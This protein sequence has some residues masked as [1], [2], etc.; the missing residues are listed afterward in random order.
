MGDFSSTVH[1]APDPKRSPLSEDRMYRLQM[2]DMSMCNVRTSMVESMLKFCPYLRKISLENIP[3][4]EQLL[5]NLGFT[6]PY[7]D[8]V[9]LAMCQG[10][11][12]KG[13]K[14][15]IENCSSLSH[16]NI[17][18]TCMSRHDVQSVIHSLPE[19]LLSLDISGNRE[20]ITDD[21]IKILCD[22]SPHLR[23]LELSDSTEITNASV[24]TIG[25]NLRSL[26]RISL[27]RCYSITPHALVNLTR[28]RSLTTINVFGMMRD[29]SLT[30]LETYLKRYKVNREPF[31]TVARPTPTN[32]KVVKM[33]NVVARSGPVV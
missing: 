18:W 5:I 22:Q 32:E 33:W 26:K 13:L 7:L 3:V 9:N 15:I 29:S 16:L 20:K 21:D 2:L 8:T 11:T 28:I 12:S 30:A 4:T 17:A 14:S 31:S 10:V 23:D 27:S 19:Q 24:D 6:S 1:G 25:F